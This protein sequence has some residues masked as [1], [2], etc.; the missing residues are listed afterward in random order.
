MIEKGNSE[1]KKNRL[2]E[3]KELSL[4]EKFFFYFLVIFFVVN[5]AASIFTC[6]NL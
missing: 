2:R 1:K 6:H 5:A 4:G 3:I